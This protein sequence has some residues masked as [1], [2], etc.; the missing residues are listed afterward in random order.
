[1][2]QILML[3]FWLSHFKGLDE[4]EQRYYEAKLMKPIAY[5]MFFGD[6]TDYFEEDC[7]RL[8]QFSSH[9]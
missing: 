7:N 8:H 1:M 5:T 6:T 9:I 4:E 3:I 2:N